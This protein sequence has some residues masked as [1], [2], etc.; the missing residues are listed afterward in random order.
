[1]ATDVSAGSK[2]GILPPYGA[3]ITP[4][5]SSTPIIFHS[6]E[7]IL[8]SGTSIILPAGFVNLYREKR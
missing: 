7:P 4:L 3:V 6:M 1:M 8:L 5:I 2:K